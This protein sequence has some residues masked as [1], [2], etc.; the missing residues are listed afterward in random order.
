MR[1]SLNSRYLRHPMTVFCTIVVVALLIATS[2]IDYSGSALIRAVYRGDLL[3]VRALIKN[4]KDVNASALDGTTPLI[5][6]AGTCNRKMVELLL[7]EGADPNSAD[8]HG[9][10]SLSVVVAAG[11]TSTSAEIFEVLLSAGAKINPKDPTALALLMNA[12]LNGNLEIVRDLLT[13]GI[14][15]NSR[16]ADARTP[17]MLAAREGF[18]GIVALLAQNGADLNAQDRYGETALMLA[19]YNGHTDVV[20]VLKF[21]GADLN[22]KDKNGATADAYASDQKHPDIVEFLQRARYEW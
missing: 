17:I 3:T 9:R 18:L 13:Q 11:K 6:A 22:K 5:A 15:A 12:V 1:Y 21:L 2:V 7:Q 16:G 8:L 14:D 10:T 20:M 19:A 4:G